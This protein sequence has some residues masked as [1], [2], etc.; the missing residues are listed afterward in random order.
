MKVRNRAQ[1]EFSRTNRN[2]WTPE[3]K[4]WK[5][6]PRQTA[7]YTVSAVWS[8]PD[9]LPTSKKLIRFSSWHNFPTNFLFNHI[10]KI[11]GFR[12]GID[13][14]RDGTVL[15]VSV[16]VSFIRLENHIEIVLGNFASVLLVRPISI[17]VPLVTNSVWKDRDSRPA[18]QFRVVRLI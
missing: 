5:I 10:L 6:P 3:S 13:I 7:V 11:G 17:L 14:W 9:F 16:P 8:S 4:N 18:G 15:Q 2:R 12:S 1:N